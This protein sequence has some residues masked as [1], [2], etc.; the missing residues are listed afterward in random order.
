[1]CRKMLRFLVRKA[2][3]TTLYSIDLQVISDLI[4]AG[5]SAE[6]DWKC[7]NCFRQPRLYVSSVPRFFSGGECICSRFARQRHL[8]LQHSWNAHKEE[9]SRMR[10][11]LLFAASAQLAH[12]FRG[13]R[14][15][16]ASYPVCTAAATALFTDN[17]SAASN[18]C[19]DTISYKWDGDDDPTDAQRSALCSCTV[20]PFN[21]PKCYWTKLKKYDINAAVHFGFAYNCSAISGKATPKV[22]EV[23]PSSTPV[24]TTAAPKTPT[25]KSTTAAPKDPSSAADCTVKQ[26]SA[27]TNALTTA[28]GGCMATT[29]YNWGG[30]SNPTNQQ[31]AE[32][33]KCTTV[34]PFDIPACS[35]EK[36][37]DKVVL[38]VHYN[39]VRSTQCP[40]FS[41]PPGMDRLS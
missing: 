12:G 8:S 29:S 39:W 28:S 11:V 26:V 30:S 19:T 24:P 40:T 20:K 27:F 21:V 7:C 6:S 15:L 16:Q 36:G 32:I 37:P 9:I 22:T 4:H 18:G 41:P 3:S 34:S 35:V 38:S 2:L 33:C 13:Q 1:M 31:Y 17:L 14:E 25:P 5:H 23:D 10:F